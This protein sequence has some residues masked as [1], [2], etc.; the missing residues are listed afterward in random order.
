MM[1]PVE[2]RMSH[3]TCIGGEVGGKC[4]EVWLLAG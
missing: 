3:V 4:E 2:S 1:Q